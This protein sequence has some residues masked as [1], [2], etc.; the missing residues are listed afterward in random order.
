MKTLT[1]PLL[2]VALSTSAAT[3]PLLSDA[4]LPHNFTLDKTV[5]YG[6]LAEVER[7][8]GAPET[9]LAFDVP[10]F[11]VF[12]PFAIIHGVDLRGWRVG[13]HEPNRSVLL[14][15]INVQYPPGQDV[16][17]APVVGLRRADSEEV[18]PAKLTLFNEPFLYNPAIIHPFTDAGSPDT[19][20]TFVIDTSL[21]DFS[22]EDYNSELRLVLD[23]PLNPPVELPFPA[24]DPQ[25]D[26]PQFPAPPLHG[27]Y[28][29]QWTVEGFPRQGLVLQI[30]EIGD[31]N[32][33]FAI[34]FTYLEGA[35]TW[36]V[37]NA[38][39]EPGANA[40]TVE[41]QRLEGGEL[42]TEPLNSYDAMD[43]SGQTLGTMTFRANSC[44]SISADVDFSSSGFGTAELS[45]QR[46]IRIAGYDCDQ[47]Q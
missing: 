45:F 36:V 15:N 7:F 14:L 29:G 6:C 1:A 8:K 4:Q 47:T 13:C 26:A 32:F 21:A 12:L 33:L 2:L 20:A 22:N 28:S 18:V 44:N 30:G 25:L 38:D 27:R 3:Q 37:G 39:F 40:V 17:W 9:G 10:L 11:A 42:F 35:P 34:M 41:M 16:T 5:P 19:G 43:I 46:L 23:W 31:R 24:Y